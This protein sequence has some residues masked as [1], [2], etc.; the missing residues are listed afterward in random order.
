MP[1]NEEITK[2]K[3]KLEE[4]EKRIEDLEKSFKSGR[5]KLVTKRKFIR[6]HLT[7]LK[8]E[9][10]FDE[11]RIVKQ[12]VEKLAEEGYHYPPESLTASLQRTIKK[13]VLGRIK[14]N[15]KWAYCK[16]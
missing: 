7:Y 11:P 3:K 8:S 6:D 16:R 10:F 1:S 14:K 15:G 12:I 4:H 13:G 2:I 5:K 9:G